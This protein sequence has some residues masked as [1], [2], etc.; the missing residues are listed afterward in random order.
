MCRQ[1]VAIKHIYNK[2][3]FFCEVVKF[4]TK[5]MESLLLEDFVAKKPPSKTYQ[6]FQKKATNF[7]ILVRKK[8][9][10]T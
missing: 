1:I 5:N 4:H 3:K 6:T 8:N 2:Y 9:P 7:S 10:V